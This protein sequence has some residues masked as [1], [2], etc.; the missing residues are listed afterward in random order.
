LTICPCCGSKRT[1][2]AS[3]GCGSCGALAVGPPLV[4]PE[5][6]L[7]SYG[8][9]FASVGAGIVL[10]GL[11]LGAFVTSVLKFDIFELEPQLVLRAAENAAWRLKWS[12]LPLSFIGVWLTARFCRSTRRN[13]ERFTGLRFVRLGFAANGLV[14]VTIAMLIGVTIPERLERRKLAQD[15]AERVF[16]YTSIQ[17]L[18]EY[19]KQFNSYPTSTADLRKLDDPDCSYSTVIALM[20]L[21]DYKPET[22]LASLAPARGKSKGSVGGARVRQISARS[23]DDLPEARIPLT[24]YALILPGSDKI[25]GTDDDLMVRDGHILDASKNR[26]NTLPT[27]A[28]KH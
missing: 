4:R 13:P 27:T 14:F 26:N 10:I 23:T 17:I 3:E 5:R 6:E 25:T 20:E 24:N 8:F 16:A 1:D 18:A 11:L 12:A 9:A 22:D 19:Q 21:G 15:A 7:P 28:K 2:N